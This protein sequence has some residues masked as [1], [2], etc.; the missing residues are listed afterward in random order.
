M[1]H[2]VSTAPDESCIA[3]ETD[4]A[5]FDDLSSSTVYMG[6]TKVAGT[7]YSEAQLTDIFL[8]FK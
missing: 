7:G 1:G 5:D 8:T 2:V 3:I 6:M 4:T